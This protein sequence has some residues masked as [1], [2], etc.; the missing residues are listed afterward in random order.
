MAAWERGEGYVFTIWLK[1]P[2]QFGGR[3]GIRQF[4][5]PATWN[6]GFWISPKLWGNGFAAEVALKIIDFGFTQLRCQRIWMAHAKWNE[7][8]KHVIKKL[9]VKFLENDSFEK[10]GD[11]IENVR[12]QITADEWRDLN[13]E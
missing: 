9:P 8:S 2:E 6:M 5:T 10:N 13:L 4:R 1:E 12:Y 11:R 3:I 7:Q